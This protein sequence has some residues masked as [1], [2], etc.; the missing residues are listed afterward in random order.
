V[1]VCV[2]VLSCVCGL[3]TSNGSLP[4][5]YRCRSGNE[6]K[7][8]RERDREREARRQGRR[9]AGTEGRRAQSRRISISGCCAI[10]LEPHSVGTT[11]MKT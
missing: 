2:R 9:E 6:R 1:C 7:S 5:Q 4:L 10:A 3:S 8:A 11:L